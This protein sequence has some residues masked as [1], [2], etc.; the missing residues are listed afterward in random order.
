MQFNLPTTKSEMYTILNDLF[1]YYRIRREGFEE[2]NLQELQLER[3]SMEEVS[4]ESLMQ[5]ANKLLSA[6]HE[7]EMLEYQEKVNSEKA[8][9]EQKIILL[10]KNLIDEIENVHKLYDESIAKIESQALKNGLVN[11]SIVVDKTASLLNSKNQKIAE[12]TQAKNDDIASLTAKK[13]TLDLIL[14]ESQ[15]F[16]NSVHQKEVEIKFEELLKEKEKLRIEVFKYNNSLDEKEQRY[17]NTLKESKA[18]LELRFLDISSGEFTKDKLIEMGYYE[19]VIKC[20]CGYYNTL[21]REDAYAD[22]V[23]ESKLIIY[24]DDYYQEIL[25]LYKTKLG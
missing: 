18:S 2:I 21:S 11:S 16:F 5:L 8:E 17:A 22:F 13:N 9:I 4:D 6:K 7:R 14:A 15:D 1:Y 3:L 20:V 25:Y 23:S 19:D 12:I 24:L 10:E